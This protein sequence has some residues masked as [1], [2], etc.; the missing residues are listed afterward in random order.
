[1]DKLNDWERDPLN[2]YELWQRTDAAGVDGR[3]FAARSVVQHTAMF[4]RFF[5]HLRKHSVTV[6]T[7]GAEHL[8]SFFAE[9]DNRC[10]PGSATHI[11]Y[12]KLIDRLTRHLIDHGLR[13]SNPSAE[14]TFAAAWPDEDPKL[15]YLDEAEDRHLQTF[16]Q[17]QPTDS[18]ARH[19]ERAITA[20]LLSTGI[21][22]AELRFAQLGH[23]VLNR[24]RSHVDVPRHGPRPERRVPVA[25]FGAA[26]LEAWSNVHPVPNSDA[27]LFPSPHGGALTDMYLSRM[28]AR[29]FDAIGIERSGG[30]PRLLRNTYARRQLIAG[31]SDG[32]VASLLGLV[33]PRTVS[34]IRATLPSAEDAPG[35]IQ[36]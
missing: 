30:G 22:A 6:A 18:F 28:I 5:R 16:V 13:E 8:D 24:V 11:R 31:R 2:A 12:L 20:L 27:L 3:P 23:I 9:V 33:S 34:R 26:A 14:F 15:D 1:M 17:P 25:D 10:S 32:D 21:T 19:R 4:D 29:V 7:F 35:D 36:P